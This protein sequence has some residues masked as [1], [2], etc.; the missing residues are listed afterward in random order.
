MASTDTTTRRGFGRVFTIIILVLLLIF[1]IWFYW[2]YFYTYSEGKRFGLLQKFSHKGNL[3]KTYEGEMIL[4]SVRSNANVP[5]ASEK[6]FFS[7]SDDA[8]ARKLMDLQGQS[9]TV[10]YK[11]KKKALGW[12]G[13]SN[14]MVDSVEV[15]SQPQTQYPQTP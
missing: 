12:R 7:V 5:L 9:I 14:Y 8:T 11:E 4:S 2:N 6:F 1:G 3:F 15:T 10:H 13:D